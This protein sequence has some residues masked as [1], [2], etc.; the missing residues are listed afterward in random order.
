MRICV[1]C[2]R[3]S[4]KSLWIGCRYAILIPPQDNFAY[5]RSV[6]LCPDLVSELNYG[7]KYNVCLF[8]NY[9]EFGEI[10][11]DLSKIVTKTDNL[12]VSLQDQ[13]NK[14]HACVRPKG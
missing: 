1:G 7:T 9:A 3:C 10:D 14:Y 6:L 5:R 11:R 2:R 13:H 12:N 4:S 8:E